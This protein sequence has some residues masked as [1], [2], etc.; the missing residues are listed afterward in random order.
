MVKELLTDIEAYC[1]RSGTDRTAFGLEAVNDGHFIRRM[2]M[3]RIPTIKTI[4]KVR[5]FI[6]RNTKAVRPRKAASK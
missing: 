5:A 2:E 4:D 6:D 1:A 3:G